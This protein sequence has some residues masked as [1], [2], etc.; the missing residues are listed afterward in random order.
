MNFD[1]KW[2]NS[3]VIVT[4]KS[5]VDFNV[6]DKANTIIIGDSRFD[7]MKFQIFD[8]S[9]VKKFNVNEKDVIMIGT[10]DKSASMWNKNIKGALV[11]TN[12]TALKLADIYTTVMQDSGWT[13]RIF[14]EITDAMK[15]C[16]C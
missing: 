3:N 7:N 4:F 5:E 1:L 10:L 13:I 8:F 2:I 16:S 15:W 11:I 14:H 9:K 12:K 6:I